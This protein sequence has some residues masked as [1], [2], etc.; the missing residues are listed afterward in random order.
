MKKDPALYLQHILESIQAIEK[1][2]EGW[3]EEAFLADRRTQDSVVRRLEIIGEAAG[4]LPGETK[5]SLRGR[6]AT[7]HRHASYLDP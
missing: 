2:T 4:K 5:A 3:P 7:D 6:L 1:Y